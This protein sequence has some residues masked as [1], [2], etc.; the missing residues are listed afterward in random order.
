MF[1]ANRQ[2]IPQTTHQF[3]TTCFKTSQRH[4]LRKAL[5]QRNIELS[6]DKHSY[7]NIECTLGNTRIQAITVAEVVTPKNGKNEGM[8]QIVVNSPE[9]EITQ[10]MSN[11]I[12]HIS[13]YANFKKIINDTIIT[14]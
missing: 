4:S 9:S 14:N 1:R 10:A 11:Y 8:I 3:Q 13:T 5:S 12:N 2:T 7:G 6:F